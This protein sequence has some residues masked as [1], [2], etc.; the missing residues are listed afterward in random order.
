M[1]LALAELKDDPHSGYTRAYVAYFAARLGDPARAEDEIIQAKEEAPSDTKVTRRSVLTY[2]ALGQ[3]DR[4]IEAL[5]E[6]PPEL[7]YELNRHPDL[8]DFRQDLRFKQV[9]AKYVKGGK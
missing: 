8:S 9:V 3:R 2:E 1:D 4:A 6:A 7:L 5:N